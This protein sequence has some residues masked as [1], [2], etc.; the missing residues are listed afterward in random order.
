M[1]E[2]R[3]AIIQPEIPGSQPVWNL[4]AMPG[5]VIQFAQLRHSRGTPRA[6]CCT[7]IAFVR[8]ADNEG[9]G[10]EG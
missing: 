2:P 1:A 4:P 9:I 10:S 5:T 6:P 7:R 3:S 8:A